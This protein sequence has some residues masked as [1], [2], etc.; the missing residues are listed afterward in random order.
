VSHP[1]A[2]LGTMIVSTTLLAAVITSRPPSTA[3]TT[4]PAN[5]TTMALLGAFA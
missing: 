2:G 5:G 1:V 4:R 3:A